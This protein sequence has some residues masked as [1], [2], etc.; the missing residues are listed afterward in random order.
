MTDHHADKRADNATGTSETMLSAHHRTFE[1]LYRITDML[2]LY[3]IWLVFVDPRSQLH[4]IV[5][6]SLVFALFQIMATL[7]RLYESQRSSQLTT[8][9]RDISKTVA[10]AFS[11]FAAIAYFFKPLYK[12][13]PHK[14]LML[15]GLGCAVALVL[16]RCLVRLLLNS[17]R[18]SGMNVRIAGIVGQGE[19]A[20]Q[21]KARL[22]S[23]RWM[24][25]V[26]RHQYHATQDR[27][28]L[29]ADAR[30]GK[31]NIVY[32]AIPLRDQENIISLLEQLADTTC[33]VFVVSDLFTQDLLHSRQLDLDGLSLISLYDTAMT[34]AQLISKRALDIIVSLIALILLGP[35][36]IALGT[37]V[38]LTSPGPALFRQ[39]RY[40]LNGKPIQVLKFRSMT[41]QDNGSV[42]V[43]ARQDDP[44]ITPLG[45]FLRRTSLDELPQFVN[46][47]LGD[48]SVVGPRPH[49]VAHNELY[50]SQIPGYMLRHKVKPGITGLAQVN[51]YRGETDTLDKMAGRIEHDLEY[52][53]N[54][55]IWLDIRLI[56][57]TA[58]G[59]FTGSQAY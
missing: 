13:V 43:Q 19:S 5:A 54:W 20:S 49:A 31:L 50:R 30:S 12:S 56:L 29:L 17:L 21:L 45:A 33:A 25:I 58:L 2:C 52:I 35:L 51:G 38:R 47:L 44:R 23:N 27:D 15:W 22:D 11:A 37:A 28:A 48:M 26:V 8:Q 4:G 34:P 41:T 55:S 46:V 42:V 18:R 39:T 9:C 10:L 59:G 14:D 57:K 40:G 24:G 36:L 6:L 1:T 7:T 3:A 53:R 32:L 16:I